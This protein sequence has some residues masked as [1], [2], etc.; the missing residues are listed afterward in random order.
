MH[1]SSL[2]RISIL[3]G[4]QKRNTGGVHWYAKGFSFAE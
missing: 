2:K 1:K 3:L 4:I